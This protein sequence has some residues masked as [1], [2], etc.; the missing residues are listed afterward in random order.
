M[1]WKESSVYIVIESSN[2]YHKGE[3]F[4]SVESK[5]SSVRVATEK[6]TASKASKAKK[7]AWASFATTDPTPLPSVSIV[8]STP[9]HFQKKDNIQTL[10]SAYT[11]S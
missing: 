7:I 5:A 11:T 1:E 6:T 2:A 10:E 9:A 3:K 8:H 4:T